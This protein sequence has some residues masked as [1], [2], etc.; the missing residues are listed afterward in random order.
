MIDWREVD[1]DGATVEGLSNVCHYG[2]GILVWGQRGGHPYAAAVSSA[3]KVT[4]ALPTWLGR[5]SGMLQDDFGDLRVTC[6][7][8]PRTPPRGRRR[9]V[10]R[11]GR[12]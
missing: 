7:R 9:R 11:G 8:P 1:L 4:D 10:G 6:G 12:G 3:G 5:V 2:R